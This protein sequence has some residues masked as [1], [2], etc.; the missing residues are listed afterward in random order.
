MRIGLDSPPRRVAFTFA[1]LL[2]T[3]SFLYGLQLHLRGALWA[4]SLHLQGLQRATDLEPSNADYWHSLGRFRL[5][6][7]QDPQA[8]ISDFHRAIAL[9][10]NVSRYWM[11]LANAE[12][13]LGNAKDQQQALEQALANDP[14]TPDVSWEAAN[15]YLSAGDNQR[16]LQNFKTVV[17]NKPD[18]AFAAFDLAWRATHDVN[19]ILRFAMPDR[20]E[21]HLSLIDVLYRAKQSNAALIVWH[22]TVKMA[23]PFKPQ[24]AMPFVQY[25]VDQRQ[26]DSLTEVWA[27]LAKMSPSFRPS[28]NDGNLIVNGDFTE[29]IIPGPLSWKMKPNP[30]VMT[31]DVDDQEFQSNS[32]SLRFVFKG[33]AFD[34]SG[35]SQFVPVKANASYELQAQVMSRE[36]ES[37]NGPRIIIVDAYTNEPIALGQEWQ[38]THVWTPEA[39]SFTTRPSTR[40]IK[41]LIGRSPSD[42]LIRGRLWIDNIRLYER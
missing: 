20:V 17:E 28:T 36:L 12:Q 35:I 19:M 5:I 27:G 32:S 18:E 25:L 10:K 15:F 11:D 34:D 4:Q 42:G 29:E 38:G 24:L 6:I 22:E 37:A 30:A 21:P 40:L 23:Q 31:V 39:F 2:L 14:K 26:I 8:A 33:S 9:N 16:A 41:V 1:A 3:I 13:L 7:S